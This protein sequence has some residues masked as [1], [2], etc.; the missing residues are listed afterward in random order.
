MPLLRRA[1]GAGG[2]DGTGA[3]NRLEFPKQ[4]DAEEAL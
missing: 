1:R 3:R 4:L 2:A